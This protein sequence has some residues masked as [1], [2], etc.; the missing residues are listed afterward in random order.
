MVGTIEDCPA[1][2]CPNV[3]H[4]EVDENGEVQVWAKRE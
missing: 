2:C 1:C 3:V 4:V